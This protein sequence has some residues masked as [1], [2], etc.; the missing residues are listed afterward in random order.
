MCGYKFNNYIG[1]FKEKTKVSFKNYKDVIINCEIIGSLI[2]ENI[3]KY[4]IQFG[5]PYYNPYYNFF[6][7]SIDISWLEDNLISETFNINDEIVFKSWN[8]LHITATICSDICEYEKDNKPFY[9]ISLI[10]PK[11]K[12]VGMDIQTIEASYLKDNLISIT[13]GKGKLK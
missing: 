8:G 6:V 7:E 10:S 11:D 5:T 13:K 4:F 12:N 3:P 1:R 2:E 9:F